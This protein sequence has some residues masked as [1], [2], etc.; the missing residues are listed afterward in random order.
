[1]IPIGFF[2]QT[3]VLRKPA[4]MTDEE[5]APL[6]IH[7]DGKQ[8]ISCWQPSWREL[9]EIIFRRRVW[10]G[11]LSGQTQ[12]PIWLSGKHPFEKHTKEIP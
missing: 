7:T 3:R 12:P 2:E 1:M 8:C 6:P 9:I 4:N 5:C 10:I 11:V